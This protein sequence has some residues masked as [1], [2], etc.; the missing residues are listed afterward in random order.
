MDGMNVLIVEMKGRMEEM[1]REVGEKRI[2]EEVRQSEE[3]SDGWSE[4]T[5]KVTYC[6]YIHN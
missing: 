2:L 3:R 5:A 4:G 1:E 6:I